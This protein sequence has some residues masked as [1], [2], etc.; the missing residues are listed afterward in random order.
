MRRTA[1]NSPQRALRSTEG[2]ED[3]VTSGVRPLLHKREQKTDGPRLFAT[4]QGW[5]KAGP[6]RRQAHF[7]A[8]K[9]GRPNM[10]WWEAL[11]C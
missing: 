9:N 10:G 8:E 1:K 3:W 6:T 4:A 2:R 7:S 5:Q 11:G